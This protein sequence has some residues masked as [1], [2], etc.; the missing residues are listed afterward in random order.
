MTTSQFQNIRDAYLKGYKIYILIITLLNL[1]DGMVE[2][3]NAMYTNT[4]NR[5]ISHT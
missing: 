5:R 2:I 3:G 4:P 1:F